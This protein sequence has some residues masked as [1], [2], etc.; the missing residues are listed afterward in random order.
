MLSKERRILTP[1][2]ILDLIAGPDV[3]LSFLAF[4]I[5]VDGSGESTFGPRHLA[6]NPANSFAGSL[7]VK[8]LVRAGM[9]E[10]KQFKELGIVIQHLLK[11]RH[12][13]VFVD[14]V[15]CKATAKMVVDAALANA[16]EG[17]L[18]QREV[19]RFAGSK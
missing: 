12:Q 18:D 13:P 9:C 16:I 19:A 5:G 2:Q 10:R 3:K 1:E 17:D 4:G 14:R 6:R 7:A 8:R 15:A 11:M